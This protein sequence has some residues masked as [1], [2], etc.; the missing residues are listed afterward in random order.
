MLTELVCIVCGRSYPPGDH[1]TCRV[2]GPEGI[3]D[4]GTTTTPSKP[5]LTLDALAR[6]APRHL[7]LPGTAPGAGRASGGPTLQVGWTPVHEAPRLAAARRRRGGSS[8]RTRAATRPVRSRT[9]RAPSAWPKALEFGYQAIA[10]ASTGNA[11]SSLAGMAASVGLRAFIFVP[12][13]APEPKVAQLLMFGATVFRVRG[14]YEQAFDLCRAA[15]ERFRWYNRNSGTNPFLVEGKKTAGLEIAEQFTTRPTARRRPARLGGGVGRRRM[16]DWR[17]HQGPARVQTARPR[18]ARCRA[19]SACRRKARARSCAPSRRRPTSCR[20]APTPSPTASPSARRATGG[21][22][23]RGS[24]RR[25]ARWWRCPT[26]TIL[27]AMRATARLG[28]GVRRTGRRRRRRRPARGRR[29][30][31]RAR[32]TPLRSPSSRA[33]G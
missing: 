19:C 11:A 5:M 28:G 30:G 6:R 27:D 24:A 14:T 25:A 12:E 16:H 10:C 21:A 9:A 26:T 32:P 22:P 1:Q 20:P 18:A 23:S 4:A 15:C 3:L 7:A 8:S 2:C 13:R 29:G 33:T 17:H 31:H